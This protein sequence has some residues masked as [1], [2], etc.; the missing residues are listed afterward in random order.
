MKAFW[1]IVGVLAAVTAVICLSNR[2]RS[3]QFGAGQSPVP[4]VIPVASDRSV[5]API[6]A[7]TKSSET[8]PAPE[9]TPSQPEPNFD[10]T[11]S[12]QSQTG[13]MRTGIARSGLDGFIRCQIRFRKGQ[14]GCGARGWLACAHDQT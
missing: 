5:Q 6:E 9:P 4:D 14:T 2:H 11:T 13:L 1:L 3:D 8:K 7:E 10:M 12:A